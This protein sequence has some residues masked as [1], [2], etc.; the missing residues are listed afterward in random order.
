MA[1]SNQE[2]NTHEKIEEFLTKMKALRA[3]II[4]VENVSIGQ[5]ITIKQQEEHIKK[6]GKSLEQYKL[7]NDEVYE[8]Y[9]RSGKRIVNLESEIEKNNI[10]IIDLE[11]CTKEKS[12]QI[13]EI[14]RELSHVKNERDNLQHE[15]NISCRNLKDASD[16]V[17]KNTILLEE[18]K[19]TKDKYERIN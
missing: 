5:K 14:S 13:A 17:G 3:R 12:I 19:A 10:K 16:T 18:M 6:L 15:L 2:D 9:A 1:K 7:H 11:K 8:K 4:E